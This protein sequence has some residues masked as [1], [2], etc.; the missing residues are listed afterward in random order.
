[1]ASQ[2]FDLI[3]L[4]GGSAAFASAIKASDLGA[5]TAMIERGAI[6]GTCVN[7]GC[8]PSKHLLTAGEL[9]YYSQINEFDRIRLRK[10][11]FDFEAIMKV[12]MNLIRDLRKRKYVDVLKALPNVNFFKGSANFF[13]EKEVMVGKDILK[14]DKFIVATSSS[15]H[16]IPIK[17]IEEIEYLTSDDA[18]DLEDLPDSMIVIGGRSLGLEFAQMY[19]HFGTEVTLLQRS[20]RIIP[21]DEPE[22]SEALR[23]YLE[24]EGTKIYTNA[25][26]KSVRGEGKRKFVKAIVDGKEREFEAEQLLMATGR[27]PN[28]KGFALE[29]TGVK[30]G[31]D[32]AVL[33]NEEMRTTAPHVWAAGDVIGEPML[34]TVAAKEGSIAAENALTN[35]HRKIDFLSIPRAIF[36]SP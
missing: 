28:T 7:R 30:V 9:I 15:P 36:T 34:E 8:V 1:M 31:E 22:I 20:P 21:E 26:L 24:E 19:S 17:G 5:K 29:K 10:Q 3:I 13:S 16:V 32:G 12:K 11:R 6:G 4:G 35:S 27:R 25:Q 2:K 14:A 23:Y 18:L 33:V